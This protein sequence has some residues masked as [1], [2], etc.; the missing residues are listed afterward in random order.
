MSICDETDAH[1]FWLTRAKCMKLISCFR[2]DRY[3]VDLLFIFNLQHL[4]GSVCFLSFSFHVLSLLEWIRASCSSLVRSWPDKQRGMEETW[5]MS[6][7]SLFSVLVS[8][9][10]KQELMMP[11]SQISVI[12]TI[13]SKCRTDNSYSF[14]LVVFKNENFALFC[15][16][17]GLKRTD[18]HHPLCHDIMVCLLKM[19]LHIFFLFLFSSQKPFILCHLCFFNSKIW[20]KEP[21]SLLQL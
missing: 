11:S 20:G 19:L 3:D 18:S 1:F 14:L 5:I 12:P 16:S 21:C 10:C 8:N 4:T 13:F 17:S 7:L 2:T 15:I 6:S 9:N